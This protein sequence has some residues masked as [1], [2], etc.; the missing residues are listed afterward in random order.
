MEEKRSSNYIHTICL[1]YFKIVSK[2][3]SITYLLLCAATSE[4]EMGSNEIAIH[5][6]GDSRI[7]N[8][9]FLNYLG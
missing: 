6:R 1:G 3:Y 9:L 2:K 7:L 5:Q 4:G 8:L